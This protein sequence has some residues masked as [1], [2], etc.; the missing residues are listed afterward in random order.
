MISYQATS[1]KDRVIFPKPWF[2]VITRI[3]I[4][5]V[6]NVGR[7]TKGGDTVEKIRLKS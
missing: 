2:S 7:K 1:E 4:V 3:D 5:S 6:L